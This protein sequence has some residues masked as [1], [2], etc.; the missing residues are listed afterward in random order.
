MP[1]PRIIGIIL[2][3]VGIALLFFGWQ[4]SES[5]GEQLREELTGRYSDQTMW[6][7]IGGGAAVIG[8]LLLAIF[9]V[10]R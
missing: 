9:G 3:A 2:I 7:L 8:G 5:V 1:L 4:A 6:Y 10:R